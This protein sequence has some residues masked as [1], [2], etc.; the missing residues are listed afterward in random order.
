MLQQMGQVP[1]Q[2]MQQA[3]QLPQGL[4]QA[5]QSGIQQVSQMTG[6]VG[7]NGEPESE[8]K[9]QQEPEKQAPASPVTGAS[10]G[11]SSPE[12]APVTGP[13]GGG[14]SE[15]APAEPKHEAAPVNPGPRRTPTDSSIL[16]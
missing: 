2:M 8:D 14:A 15:N 12:R 9:D 4:M 7:K 10:D 1:M 5:A 16:L 3:G 13:S 6:E 11:G